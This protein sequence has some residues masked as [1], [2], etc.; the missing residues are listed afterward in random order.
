[1]LV[2]YPYLWQKDALQNKG[3]RSVYAPVVFERSI[4]LPERF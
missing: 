3:G 1:M 4:W 2:S